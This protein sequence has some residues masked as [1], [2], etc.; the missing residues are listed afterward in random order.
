MNYFKNSNIFK[1][2]ISIIL[3]NFEFINFD[4]RLIFNDFKNPQ[5]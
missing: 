3:C 1:I 2:L 5:V 4:I